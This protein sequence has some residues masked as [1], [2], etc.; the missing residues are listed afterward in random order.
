MSNEVAQSRQATG[1]LLAA[2]GAFLLATVVTGRVTAG[3]MWAGITFLVAWVVA[4]VMA[5]EQGRTAAEQ[6]NGQGDT[7]A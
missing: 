1:T 5:V 6:A 2:F 7:A 4:R 3:V